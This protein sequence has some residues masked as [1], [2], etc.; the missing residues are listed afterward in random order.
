MKLSWAA[1]LVSHRDKQIDGELSIPAVEGR[2]EA[3]MTVNW[4][5]NTQPSKER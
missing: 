1:A 5:W 3:A 2:K 4:V